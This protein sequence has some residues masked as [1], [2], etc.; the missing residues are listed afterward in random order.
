MTFFSKK[1]NK[2]PVSTQKE[3]EQI[4]TYSVEWIEIDGY[5]AVDI[6]MKSFH[7]DFL[8]EIGKTYT[9]EGA[10][11]PCK[12]G[13]HFCKTLEKTI[14]LF[15]PIYGRRYFKVLALV[16]AT[17]WIDNDFREHISPKDC[18]NL[19]YEEAMINYSASAQNGMDIYFSRPEPWKFN[20]LADK[21][22]SKKITL[23]EEVPFEE[24]SEQAFKSSIFIENEKDYRTL[25]STTQIEAKALQMWKE[26]TNGIFSEG[27]SVYIFEEYIKKQKEKSSILRL[28]NTYKALC[29]TLE[30]VKDENISQDMKT[31][32]MLKFSGII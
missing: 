6:N 16:P 12:N 27:F 9:A 25:N 8:F 24:Y 10:L 11:R 2:E 5:K 20:D 29:K 19:A 14:E 23:I 4:R 13:F 17:K 1:V 31:L 21:Y 22:V 18:K 30:A 3:K 32:Y 15:P 7:G 26:R 28:E